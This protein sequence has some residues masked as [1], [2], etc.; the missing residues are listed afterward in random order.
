MD[1][2]GQ[3]GEE[4][5]GRSWQIPVEGLAPMAPLFGLFLPRTPQLTQTR[6]H[7][8]D[9]EELETNLLSCR[10]LFAQLPCWFWPAQPLGEA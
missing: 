7:S 1:E 2:D 9:G 6:I 10:G 5:G 8:W 4:M 3:D